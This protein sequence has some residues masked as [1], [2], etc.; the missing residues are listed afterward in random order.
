MRRSVLILMLDVMVLSVLSMAL[1]GGDIRFPVPIYRLSEMIERGMEKEAELQERINILRASA[2]QAVAARQQAELRADVA[3]ERERLARLESE[4]R[5]T[6]AMRAERDAREAQVLARRAEAAAA[7]EGGRREQ[8]SEEAQRARER[9]ERA[10]AQAIEAERRAAEAR[11]RADAVDEALVEASLRIEDVA[12]REQEA[13]SRAQEAEFRARET[14]T[15]IELTERHIEEVREMIRDAVDMERTYAERMADALSR[16]AEVR[17]RADVMESELHK[18]QELASAAQS[19]IEELRGTV[20]ELH[21]REDVALRDLASA[22]DEREAI[23]QQMQ[24]I[25]DEKQQSVWVKRE[26]A[27]RRLS[28]VMEERVRRGTGERREV[29]L[30]LPLVNLGNR[31]FLVTEFRTLELDWWKIQYDRNI[32]TLRYD[33]RKPGAADEDSLRALSMIA[34]D[35]EPRMCLVIAQDTPV[36]EALKPIGMRTLKEERLSR[37]LLFDRYSANRSLRVEVTP[38]LSDNFLI[39]KTAEPASRMRIRQGDY[40][41]TENGRF[42][43]VMIDS[44]HCFV[45]P[46]EL[47]SRDI[48]LQ[49]PLIKPAGQEIHERFIDGARELRTRIRAIS[50]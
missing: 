6:L 39:V 23:E 20:S 50:N 4:Q 37:A 1:G 30:Y 25:E 40:L 28:V 32:A 17:G 43:G 13:L 38:S 48:A 7:T 47:P 12:R 8:L 21:V 11:G 2:D 35:A 15:R 44:E 5:Q 33:I 3:E 18:V 22:R 49:I 31:N 45:M 27:M 16:E 29:E 41:L 24:E 26:A 46:E 19:R 42:I 9:E 10:L 14:E 34:L 36:E